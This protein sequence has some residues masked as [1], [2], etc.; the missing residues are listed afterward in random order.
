MISLEYVAG[1][2][3]G[4]GCVDATSKD[5]NVYPRAHINST[6]YFVLKEFKAKFGGT[7]FPLKG[8]DPK[9]KPAYRWVVQGRRALEFF[10]MI[11]PYSIAKLPQIDMALNFKGLIRNRGHVELD[12]S[13]RELRLQIKKNLHLMKHYNKRVEDVCGV[14]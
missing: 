10:E 3:D 8:R 5:G 11:K 12:T 9:H 4:E 6:D 7:F 13:E 1:Y 14:G 2:F